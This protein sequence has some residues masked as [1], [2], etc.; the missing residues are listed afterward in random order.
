MFLAFVVLLMIC[1][2]IGVLVWLAWQKVT[3]HM[4][5]H[6]EAAKLIAEHIIAPLLA[7]KPEETQET[8]E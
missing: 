7:G 1:A 5:N 8:T 3:A 6:P 2:G 4:R